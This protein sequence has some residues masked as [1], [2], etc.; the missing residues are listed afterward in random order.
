MQGVL[1]R[2]CGYIMCPTWFP[3]V[4]FSNGLQILRT[5]ILRGSPWLYDPYLVAFDPVLQAGRF[6]SATEQDFI[7]F[8]VVFHPNY[9]TPACLV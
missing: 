4:V 6:R 5:S 3:I 7:D 2:S 8:G 1:W 9:L